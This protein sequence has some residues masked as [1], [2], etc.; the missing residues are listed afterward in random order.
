ML[1][2]SDSLRVEPVSQGAVDE[3]GFGGVQRRGERQY[4]VA[5]LDVHHD[6]SGIH[7]QTSIDPEGIFDKPSCGPR[8][9]V[10]ERRPYLE[11][12]WVVAFANDIH[13][14]SGIRK[15]SGI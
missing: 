12:V 8:L 9:G 11:I 2:P 1:T 13:Q 4:P 15:Q 6:G 3:E 5:A 7:T 10:A 14:V